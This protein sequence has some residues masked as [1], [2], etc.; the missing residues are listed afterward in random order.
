[1]KSVTSF[2]TEL[3]NAVKAAGQLAASVGE[4]IVLS[5]NAIGILLCDADM[6]GAAVTEELHKLLG[7]D[8]A[9]MTTLGTL[10][11]DGY[12]EAAA[13]FTVLTAD[14]CVFYAAASE[15]LAESNFKQRIT[16]SAKSVTPEK[17]GSMNGLFFAFCPNGMP[18]SGDTYPDMLSKAT[19]GVP[20]IGG[21]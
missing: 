16:A 7:I 10:D 13:V 18:F 14:D 8:I 1:M 4:R 15:S 2:T 20:V 19:G 6:D 11:K 21:V 9:G 5:K 17:H 3:D 12:H